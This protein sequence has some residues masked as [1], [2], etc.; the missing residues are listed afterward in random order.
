MGLLWKTFTRHYLWK[1]LFFVCLL[2]LVGSFYTD[3]YAFLKSGKLSFLSGA[4]TS[5]AATYTGD[6]VRLDF[7]V[8]SQCPYGV[9]VE[10]GVDPVLKR[11]GS[12]VDYN[13]YFIGNANGG[14]FQSLHG[15]P[16]VDED[17]RQVCIQGKFKG[18]FVDY[19]SCVNKDISSVAGTWEGC[20]RDAGIDAEAVRACSTGAEGKSLLTASFKASDDVGASGSPTMFLNGQPYQGGRDALSFQ[21][22]LC[23]GLKSHPECLSMPECAADADCAAQDGKESSCQGGKCVYGDAVMVELTI[24]N[25]KRCSSCD[26]SS[27]VATTRKYFPGTVVREVDAS[28][29]EGK[30]L[31]GKYQLKFAPSY[32]F[33]KSLEEA[34]MWVAEPRIRGSFAA[35]SDGYRLLDEATGASFW[36]DEKARAAQVASMGITLGDNKPTVNLFVMSQCPYGVQAEAAMKPVLDALGDSVEFKL[37][38]IAGDNGDG[39]FKSLHGQAEADEDI[40]QLCIKK[41]APKKLMDYVMCQN[42]DARNVAAN[43]EKCASEVGVD[44]DQLKSCAEGAE[45]KELMSKSVEL[46]NTFGASGSPTMAI[47]GADYQGARTSTGFMAAI[48]LA[49]DGAKPEGCNTKFADADQQ[50]SATAAGGCQ[51]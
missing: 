35:T 26:T 50:A 14:A 28:S 10:T 5:G 8:M 49:F 31:V 30:A 6:T 45:G 1:T 24:L 23:Q 25:D 48:C 3:N 34:S 51:V 12:A 15:Q 44:K 29:D 46:A 20:A 21:R 33:G 13:V 27:I 38:F 17:L 18:K 42:K 40:R 41:L 32:L 2:L 16:E 47:D 22:A 7:Y 37:D 9:Q 19:L 43:W 4:N 36:L 39:T 11:L